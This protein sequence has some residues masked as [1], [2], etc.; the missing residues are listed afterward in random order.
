VKE[1]TSGIGFAY[2]GTE[3]VAFRGNESTNGSPFENQ[4]LWDFTNK[5]VPAMAAFKKD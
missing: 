2:W 4:A 1:T 5:A 3:W